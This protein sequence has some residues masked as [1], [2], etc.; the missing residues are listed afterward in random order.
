MT[1]F[2]K[3]KSLPLK[4]LWRTCMFTSIFM[5]LGIC[6]FASLGFGIIVNRVVGL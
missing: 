1:D 3:Q 5:V 6:T 2:P 4:T